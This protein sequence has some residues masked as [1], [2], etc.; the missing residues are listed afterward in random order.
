MAIARETATT[1]EGLTELDGIHNAI[2]SRTLPVSES[3]HVYTRWS[4]T[5]VHAVDVKIV[6]RST[7]T[8]LAES[9]DSLD[10]GDSPVTWFIHDFGSTSFPSAGT[11]AIEV[12]LDDQPAATYALYVNAEEEL[13]DQPAF[14]I[15]VPAER[16][17]LDRRGDGKVTGIFEY[18]SVPSF[19]ARETFAIVTVWFSGNGTLRHSAD[20]RDAHGNL[21]A[22][23]PSITLAATRGG[24]SIATNTFDSVE[25]PSAGTY[26]ATVY[27]EGNKVL[28]YPVVIRQR[29]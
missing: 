9:S 19:P 2:W 24:M 23:S 10:F 20:I 27:L 26:T 11:Y 1:P 18:F 14:V 29:K 15:S 4:G 3:L 7:D 12:A 22:R 21:V 13:P 5:G 16:G 6:D 25:F 28:S 17:L 8:S